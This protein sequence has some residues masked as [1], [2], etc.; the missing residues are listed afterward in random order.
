MELDDRL[1]VLGLNRARLAERLGVSKA[2][3]SQW[4]EVPDKAEELLL[5]L[6]RDSVGAI[7]LGAAVRC[8]DGTVGRVVIVERN[9]CLFGSKKMRWVY[10]VSE[11]SRDAEGKWKLVGPARRWPESSLKQ[12]ESLDWA[13][14][15]ANVRE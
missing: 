13:E 9:E 5:G 10:L 15:K 4:K 8:D 14:A 11:A 1:L 6:E 2:A 3:V 7:P 12:I